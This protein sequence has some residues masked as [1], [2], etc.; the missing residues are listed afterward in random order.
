MLTDQA[1][2]SAAPRERSYKLADGKGLY[3]FVT[4][5][6]A[7]SW[8]LKYRIDGREHRLTFGLHP[9]VTIEEARELRD[10]ARSILARNGDPRQSVRPVHAKSITRIRDLAISP[11]VSVYFVQ[12]SHGPIKIGVATNVPVRI[13][14]LQC[15]NPDPLTLLGALPGSYGHE[16]LLHRLFA[17]DRMAG[18]W[19]RQSDRLL[20]FI[21]DQ[22]GAARWL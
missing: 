12:A 1:V 9:H 18:E 11:G 4:T 10:E 5:K 13:A 7:K 6:G 2:E 21:S 22:L 16:M 17:A 20:H 15:A 19:F 14:D 3:L 8:R